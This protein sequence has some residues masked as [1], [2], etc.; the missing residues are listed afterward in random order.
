MAHAQKVKRTGVI[1]LVIHCERREG[2]ELSNK[3]IDMSRTHL[4]YNLAETI[5][6]MKPEIFIKKRI[7]EVKHIKRDDI[8]YLVDWIVT[9]PKDVLADDQERFFKYTY[10]FLRE[11]YGIQNIVSAWVHNDEATPHI[12]FSFIPV[13]EIDGIE[14]LKCKDILTKKELKRFHPDLGAYLENRLG[15]M[16]AIQNDATINGNRTIKEL[17][18]QED[19]SLKKSLKNV[20]DHIEASKNI[21]VE[22][23]KINYETTNIFEKTKSLKKS[24]QVIDE[25]KNTNKQL[26][27]DVRTLSHLTLTQKKEIDSYRQMPLAKQLKEKNQVINNLYDSIFSLEK[28]IKDQEYDFSCLRNNYDRLEN[29]T[30]KLKNQIFIHEAFLSLIGLDKVFNEFKRIFTRNDYSIN[31]DIL[32]D[33]CFKTIKKSAMMFKT[34]KERI[35]FLSQQNISNEDVFLKKEQHSYKDISR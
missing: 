6:P 33:I 17:K 31:I 8:V 26:Q 1:G 19:L 7:D 27:Y 12:H 22:S 28:Q 21:I 10:D 34:L 32:K 25:L 11:K 18:N 13:V 29:K 3:D 20:Y 24:H 15:Y 2:C 14:R 4:N 16:P 35:N 30:E 5:Q 9:L 23:N